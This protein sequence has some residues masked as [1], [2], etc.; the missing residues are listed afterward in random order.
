M[1]MTKAEA[2]Y[3]LNHPHNIQEAVRKY[4]LALARKT[5]R[6]AASTRSDK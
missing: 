3:W 1:K 5:L 4:I 6:G 2:R